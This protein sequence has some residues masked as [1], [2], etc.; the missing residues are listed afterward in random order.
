[1]DGADLLVMPLTGQARI[2]LAAYDSGRQ[3]RA[4]HYIER[5]QGADP[6]LEQR[7]GCELPLNVPRVRPLVL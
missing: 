2:K 6:L 3:I 1:M 7:G 4:H 5:A